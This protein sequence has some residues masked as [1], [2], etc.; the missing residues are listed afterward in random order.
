MTSWRV[1]GSGEATAVLKVATNSVAV[2]VETAT[3]AIARCLDCKGKMIRKGV[4]IVS[5]KFLDLYTSMP[6]SSAVVSLQHLALDGG[7]DISIGR[8]N[9]R[10]IHRTDH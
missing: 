1:L 4:I 8:C 7:G 6:G 5:V 9:G 3:D 2:A 10:S